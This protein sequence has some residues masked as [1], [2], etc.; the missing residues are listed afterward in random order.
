MVYF[1][2]DVK[3]EYGI[4]FNVI[5][6]ESDDQLIKL[7]Y[8][9][10][11]PVNGK[12]FYTDHYLLVSKNKEFI[13]NNYDLENKNIGVLTKDLDYIKSFLKDLNINYQNYD[14]IDS[15]FNSL[16]TDVNYIIIPRMEY[17]DKILTNNLN[18][19]YHFS[20]INSYYSLEGTQDVLSN[21]LYKY[22]DIWQEKTN[23]YIK[24]EE[25]AIFKK[26]LNIADTDIDKLLSVNYNYGFIN[27]YHMKL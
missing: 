25:L 17:I 5:T 8:S 26:S 3:E 20:D 9:N 7:T 1:L 21:I 11:I 19:I 16:D 27:N 22:F 12:I 10:N 4:N 14:D 6:N 2:N 13:R 15:L 23:Q 24:S 18:I